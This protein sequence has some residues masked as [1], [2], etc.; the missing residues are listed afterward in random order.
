MR[1]NPLQVSRYGR[2][3]QAHLRLVNG[4]CEYPAT[5]LR[6]NLQ[7]HF[8]ADERALFTYVRPCARPTVVNALRRASVINSEISRHSVTYERQAAPLESILQEVF[9]RIWNEVDDAK[10]IDRQE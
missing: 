8:F 4:R 10:A 2:T 6:I 5:E 9:D 3:R 1:G 7:K